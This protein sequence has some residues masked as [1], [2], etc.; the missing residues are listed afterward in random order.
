MPGGGARLAANAL[1]RICANAPSSHPRG[2]H[3]LCVVRASAAPERR[4]GALVGAELPGR[5][6]VGA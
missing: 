3:G 2:D 6:A 5:G 1:V 4:R